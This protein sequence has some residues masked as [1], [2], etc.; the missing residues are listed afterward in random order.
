MKTLY[1]VIDN[2]ALAD[3]GT[4]IY[5]KITECCVKLSNRK[6]CE[7]AETYKTQ[8]REMKKLNNVIDNNALAAKK[9]LTDI[10]L[11]YGQFQMVATKLIS[12][13]KISDELLEAIHPD[14][15]KEFDQKWTEIRCSDISRTMGA[16]A[17]VRFCL[18]LILLVLGQEFTSARY[19]ER[20]Q[21]APRSIEDK[22]EDSGTVLSSQKRSL[23]TAFTPVT[24]SAQ[25]GFLLVDL[26]TDIYLKITECCGKLSNPKNLLTDT[27]LGY[28]Q[29]QMVATM[30]LSIIKI[31]D[32]LLEAIHP[33][34]VK[35]FDRKWTEIRAAIRAKNQTV[36]RWSNTELQTEFQSVFD[37]VD[38]AVMSIAGYLAF[39]IDGAVRLGYKRYTI[40]KINK[41]LASFAQAG[42]GDYKQLV[43][44]R[45]TK[46]DKVLGID[47]LDDYIKSTKTSMKNA[48]LSSGSSGKW[49]SRLKTTWR[50]MAGAATLVTEALTIYSIIKKP[51]QCDAME[52]N[53]RE[54]A[55]KI[56]AANNN[57]KELNKNITDYMSFL[58]KKGAEYIRTKLRADD[59][60][61]T[62]RNVVAM[63]DQASDRSA[64]NSHAAS[65]IR[66]YLA[67]INTASLP[68]TYD[69][70]VKLSKGLSQVAYLYKCYLNKVQ[71]AKYV[72]R[73]CK[74]GAGDLSTIWHDGSRDWSTEEKDC[75]SYNG[76]PYYTMSDARNDVTSTAKREGFY[77]HCH[78]NKKNQ[79]KKH[80]G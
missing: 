76:I 78:L 65:L 38:S 47:R 8:S 35:E 37:R 56:T 45:H 39:L 10:E 50:V 57:L 42:S 63:L 5:L 61:N 41:D 71:L 58:N 36:I 16:R 23:G 33:D 40:N 29:F 26:G 49:A 70:N 27:E 46:A 67:K 3:L 48:R 60:H 55:H 43:N 64:N 62:L 52:K 53:A 72:I 9:L 21:N 79:K 73:N 22:K 44:A 12:I 77:P 6:L 4:N 1:N 31:S 51:Q 19:V 30:L 24:M 80:A 11:G 17:A 15:V 54:G 20:P 34:I 69:L 74:Q 13:I 68:E 59:L 2:N 32:E 7:Y 25:V 75:L 14:I 28:G 66:E 18:F